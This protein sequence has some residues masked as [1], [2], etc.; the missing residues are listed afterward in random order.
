MMAKVSAMDIYKLLPKTNCK[1][2][3]EP[4]CMAFATKLQNKEAMVVQCPI[5][6]NSK[7]E[8]NKNTLIELLSPPVKEVW[9]GHDD[10]KCV[11]GGDEVMYR[12]E[13]SF[14]NQ[15][16]IGVDVSDN[17]TE[18]EIKN[19]AKYIE[20]FVFER[21]GERLKLDFIA[22]RNASNDPEKFKTAI[23]IVQETTK[24]PI[25]I[26]SL[27]PNNICEALGVVRSKPLIYA[28]NEDNFVELVKILVEKKKSGKDFALVLSSNDVKK[29]KA[30][31]T[32]CAKH[33]I[34]D[35]V[36]DPHTTPENIAETMDKFVMIRR[37]AIEKK[38]R[39]LGY[40]LLALPINTY[41]YAMNN[42]NPMGDFIGEKDKVAGILEA[43]TANVLL[44]RYA[45]IMIIHGTETW[46][47]MPIL[48]LRQAIYTDPRKPQ[49][50]E[51]G[52]YPVGNPD[53]NSPVIMTT[54]FSLTFYTVTGDFEKD[55]VNCWLLALDTEG[56][57]VDVSV[58]GGQYCGENAKNLIEETKL[59][60][61]VNHRIIILPGLAASTRGD[62]EDK[63]GWTCV[64]GTR[65]SSQ[66]GEFLRKNW[67]N[68]LNEWKEKNTN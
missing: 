35:L 13:L 25:A 23:K 42:E 37:S 56:K 49:A 19:R 40:P 27:N 45:D 22:I 65:D 44:N 12:Y 4:S 11:V 7:F 50:V 68:I 48:T 32:E 59:E 58:A 43:K 21:T 52:L 31:A 62:I 17:L 30:M 16:P 60:E 61:K 36:L 9:F 55:D 26:C 63:T 66:V 10:K 57:A 47:L 39:A 51:P 29:L 53:E 3:G 6:N 2:C 28:A 14:F 46:E 54:N 5:L 1:K 64:V 34:E 38:D 8:K 33:G 15:T 24:L 41:F 18:E 67:E 20:E